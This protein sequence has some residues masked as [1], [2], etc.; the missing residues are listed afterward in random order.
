[1]K[2]KKIDERKTFRLQIQ[3]DKL[4]FLTPHL[5]GGEIS[6][7]NIDRINAYPKIDKIHISGLN[8]ET[9][10]YFVEKHGNKFVS[11]EFF[12][13]PKIS[14]LSSLSQLTNIEEIMFYWNQK[15]S[16]LWD[17]TNNKKLKIIEIYDFRKVIDLDYLSTAQNL[18][19]LIIG[20]LDLHG[21][22]ILLSIEP[23]SKLNKLEE[24]RLGVDKIIENDF[25][26][27]STLKSLKLIHFP[28]N[29]YKLEVLAW[30]KVHL[31]SEASKNLEAP[32]KTIEEPFDIGTKIVDVYG[33]GKGKRRWLNAETDKKIID[34]MKKEFN[35]FYTK[36]NN[37]KNLVPKK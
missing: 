21:K 31:T 32:L 17:M 4:I 25:T 2:A 26:V 12:K 20:S 37:D 9:L 8:D 36:F 29:M 13:C 27:F 30:L 23:I 1:M 16:K 22:T 10:E 15:S 18:T 35:T 7:E 3:D 24:L 33:I 19:K 14:D 6:K 34:K 28:A 11:I 5:G